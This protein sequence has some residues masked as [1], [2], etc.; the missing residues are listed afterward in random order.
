MGN[1]VVVQVIGLIGTALFFM[2]YQCKSNKNLFRVQ[3]LS[4]LFYTTHLILLGAVTGGVSYIINGI[5]SFCL[6]SKID[7]LRSRKMCVI[8]CMLQLM[9][10]IITWSGWLSLLP[11]AANIASTIGGYTHNARKIRIAGMFVNSPL[12]IIYDIIVGSWAGILDELVS[13]GSM[14]ISIVRYGWKELDKVNS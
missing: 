10:L 2:S 9:T 12:W 14:I 4:Y 8:I 5:R 13:E 7:F 3:F 11:V 1:N 6:G